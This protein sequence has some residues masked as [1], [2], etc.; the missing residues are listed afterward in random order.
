MSEPTAGATAVAGERAGAILEAEGVTKRFGGIQ[1]V[2]GASMRVREGSITA[3]IGPNGAG[4]TTFF[5][6]ITGFYRAD[7]GTVSFDGH[8][9]SGKPP[10]SIARLGMIRTFNA[11]N[12]E[13]IGNPAVLAGGI[14]EALITTAAGLTIAIPA[15]I[16]YKYL[17]GRVQQ[18]V[19]QMEK[20]AIKLVQ[21][22]E[23]QA[24]GAGGAGR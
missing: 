3:L 22:M 12:T 2:N 15:L 16:G 7:T 23:G 18:L 14:A 13:G 8:P 5:N 19:V 20:E 6:L 24:L 1:A 17:R 11:I 4:K 10:Y 9:I 21:A